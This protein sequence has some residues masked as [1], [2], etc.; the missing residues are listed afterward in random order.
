ME[1]LP[2]DKIQRRGGGGIQIQEEPHSK[3]LGGHPQAHIIIII[4]KCSGTTQWQ[5]PLGNEV[6]AITEGWP[7]LRSVLLHCI[8]QHYN[9]EVRTKVAKGFHY[10]HLN[11]RTVCM[12]LFFV[13]RQCFPQ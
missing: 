4:L 10:K 3:L 11:T 13:I 9:N 1:I 8:L 7:Y 12:N 6:W 5:P 2:S